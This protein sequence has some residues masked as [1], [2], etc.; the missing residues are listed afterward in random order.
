MAQFCNRF[1]PESLGYA[2]HA[3][4]QWRNLCLGYNGVGGSIDGAA[5]GGRDPNLQLAGQWDLRR[6]R[7]RTRHKYSCRGA[8]ARFVNV[9]VIRSALYYW[10]CNEAIED[11]S[12]IAGCCKYHGRSL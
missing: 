7:R 12:P 6:R 4:L 5:A 3:Y 9:K 2:L 10:A 1:E 11:L 8:W